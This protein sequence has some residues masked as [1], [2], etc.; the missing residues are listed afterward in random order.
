VDAQAFKHMPVSSH[1]YGA[2]SVVPLGPVT[3]W[4]PSQA[5]ATQLPPLHV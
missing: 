5:P 2:Q 4:S 3:V 1:R